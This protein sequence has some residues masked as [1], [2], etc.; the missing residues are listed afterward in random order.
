MTKEK[1]EIKKH[2]KMYVTDDWLK[3]IQ[4]AAILEGMTQSAYLFSVIK[5]KLNR[6]KK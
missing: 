5:T 1:K 2:I 6:A 4:T 3:Q